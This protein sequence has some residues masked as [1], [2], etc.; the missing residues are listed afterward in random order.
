MLIEP[1]LGR[2]RRVGCATEGPS[3]RSVVS[4]KRA[5]RRS[6]PSGRQ[7]A[8]RGIYAA[9]EGSGRIGSGSIPRPSSP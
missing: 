9:L 3:V 6:F 5:S 8:E 4:G 1:P 2:A 7:Q